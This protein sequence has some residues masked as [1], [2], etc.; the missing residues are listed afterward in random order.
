MPVQQFKRKPKFI[1]AI[2]WI[3]TPSY[4]EVCEFVGQD[5]TYIGAKKLLEIPIGNHFEYAE[6]QDY[7][8]KDEDGN[9]SIMKL[10][11]LLVL[12]DEVTS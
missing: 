10:N 2:Q 1:S 4:W 3:D 7:I 5:L 11:D 6:P 12:Y 8:V 9:I